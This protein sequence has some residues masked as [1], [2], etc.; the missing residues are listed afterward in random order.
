MRQFTF[1]LLL[2]SFFLAGCKKED[3]TPPARSYPNQ[4][5]GIRF[6]LYEEEQLYEDDTLRNKLAIKNLG[7]EVLQKGDV[8]KTA[9]VIGGVVWAFDLMSAGPTSIVLDRDLKVG[10]EIEINP[11]YLY[12]PD[13]LDYF[14]TEDVEVCIL[15]YGAND[16]AT[17]LTFGSDPKK[18]NNRQC[19]TYSRSGVIKL[20]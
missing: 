1:F 17:D 19:V 6:A 7:P 2:I 5:L 9:C 14:E 18:N 13:I 15:V 20:N 3:P 11:G 12:G 16:A 10:E 4:D 8:I